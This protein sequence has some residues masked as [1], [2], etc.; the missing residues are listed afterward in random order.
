[1]RVGDLRCASCRSRPADL[2]ADRQLVP[3]PVLVKVY[4]AHWLWTC[5]E[6]HDNATRVRCQDGQTTVETTLT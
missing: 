4:E 3:D 5:D 1:M 2:P 6:G